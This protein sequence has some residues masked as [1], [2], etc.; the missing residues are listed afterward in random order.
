[1]EQPYR[2]I[3]AGHTCVHKDL[4]SSTMLS[5]CSCGCMP[6]AFAASAIFSPCSSV[7]VTNLTRLPCRRCEYH[8]PHVRRVSSKASSR[9]GT[10][11]ESDTEAY[12]ISCSSICCDCGIRATHMGTCIMLHASRQGCR[13]GCVWA[14]TGHCQPAL[15]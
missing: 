13:T 6:R 10:F 14:K 7:P 4:Y 3:S 8:Q 5:Q 12:L 2:C 1:M 15:T 9:Y 11:G